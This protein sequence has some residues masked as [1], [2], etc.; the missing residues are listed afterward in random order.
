[1]LEN[2]GQAGTK[3]PNSLAIVAAQ[4]VV[5]QAQEFNDHAREAGE[6]RRAEERGRALEQ[7][8]ISRDDDDDTVQ[9]ALSDASNDASSDASNNSSSSS[10]PAAH[11]VAQTTRGTAVDLNA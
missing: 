1:M 4:T 8:Q 3:V 2:T 5:A 6:R 9:V 11:V 7:L 10:T